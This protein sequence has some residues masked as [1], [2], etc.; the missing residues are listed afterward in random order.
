MRW[1]IALAVVLAIGSISLAPAARAGDAI[2]E[3]GD[4]LQ[5]VLPAGGAAAAIATQDWEGLGQLGGSWVTTTAAT[6]VLKFGTQKNRPSGDSSLSFPSGHAASA[7][8]GA[9]FIHRR[10]GPWFGVPAYLA[11]TFVGYSRIYADKHFLDDVVAGASIALLSNWA[12]VSPLPS[13]LAVGPTA[14]GTGYGL[15]FS[16]PLGGPPGGGVGAGTGTGGSTEADAP[17]YRATARLFGVGDPAPV[18]DPADDPFYEPRY[19]FEFD[20]GPVFQGRNQVR[21]SRGGGAPLDLAGWGGSGPTASASATVEFF[22][23]DQHE[24]ELGILPYGARE[25]DR[26]LATTVF[27]GVAFPAFLDTDAKFTLNDFRGTY[28]YRLF[29]AERVSATVGAALSVQEWETRLESAFLVKSTIRRW[30]VFPLL[31]VGLDIG[32]APPLRLSLEGNGMTLGADYT[33]DASIRLRYQMARHWD[34]GIGWRINARGLDH[35]EVRSDFWSHTAFVS[36]G[37]RWGQRGG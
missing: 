33:G 18:D 9:A 29:A 14:I 10:Y 25:S 3:A 26:F 28:R 37:Y 11:A 20:L 7:F 17:L 35:P 32:L 24:V 27:N 5:I 36:F 21:A 8:S 13:R 6:Q 2:E 34:I 16:M 30:T 15:G 1:R 12:W 19:R 31:H 4:I 22:L 23:T